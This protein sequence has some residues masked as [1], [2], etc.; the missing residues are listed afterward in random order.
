VRK[1]VFG[2]DIRFCVGGGALL[3]VKQQEFF[4]ALGVPIYQG[5]GLTEAAPIISANTPRRHK[6]GT[7]GP[8]FRSVECRFVKA[9]GS[10]AAPGET[11]E[12]VIRGG[13]VMKGYFKNPEA[14][15]KALR[16]GW[17]YTGDL[18]HMDP[19]GFLVVVG[20]EKALLIA[21]DGEK[22][23]P[24]E[25]EEA[26]AFSTDVVDQIMAYCDHKKHTTALVCLD[27]GKVERLVKA[28]GISSA[29]ALL[30]ALTEELNRYRSDPKAK[31]V[32]AS[33]V[34]SVFQFVPEAFSDK[35]GTMNSTMK[36]VRHRIGEVHRDLLEY[37]YSREGSKTDN[38]RNLAALRALFKLP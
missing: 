29:A 18:A 19:D 37:S 3:D 24:E 34:P 28:R 30:A 9:D 21:E 7:S 2:K 38:P 36:I 1:A 15:A 27:T 8:V 33:W 5:Y 35:D 20:R 6:F 14:T 22:Y 11:A 25:I 12:L 23:S 32:Q 4:A 26:V 13:N 16:D 10:E 17:L 31:K